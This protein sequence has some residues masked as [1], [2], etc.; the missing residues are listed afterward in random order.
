MYN[1][2]S[3]PS[4]FSTLPPIPTVLTSA[5]AKNTEK[6]NLHTEAMEGRINLGLTKINIHNS[7]DE[8]TFS[9][10]KVNCSSRF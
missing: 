8:E 4:T 9:T 3:L 6:E 5:I 2:S 10:E 1:L 7:L